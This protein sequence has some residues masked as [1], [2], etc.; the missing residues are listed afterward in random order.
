MEWF[1]VDVVSRP[2]GLVHLKLE[3]LAEHAMLDLGFPWLMG[4]K[5]PL[6]ATA[7]PLM[8][9]PTVDACLPAAVEA[10]LATTAWVRHECL[11]LVELRLLAKEGAG[12]QR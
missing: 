1:L 11:V 10:W 2:R 9:L 12:L 5:L 4:S 3:L 7:A 8:I 6:L